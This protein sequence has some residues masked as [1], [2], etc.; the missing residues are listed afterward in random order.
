MGYIEVFDYTTLRFELG[1]GHSSTS[2]KCLIPPGLHIQVGYPGDHIHAAFFGGCP[3][4]AILS[5]TQ[6]SFLAQAR[7]IQEHTRYPFPACL[8]DIPA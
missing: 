1:V 3:R 7:L 4:R 8:I 5:G 6:F 2:V